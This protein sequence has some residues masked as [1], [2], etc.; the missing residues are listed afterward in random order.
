MIEIIPAVMPTSTTDLQ[1]KLAQVAGHMSVVQIDVMDGKFVKNVSWPYTEDEE[2]FQGILNE[3]E[4]LP[5]WDQFDFEV[6]LMIVRPEE[7]INDWI[8]A[9]VRRIVVHQESTDN[10]E[11]IITDFRERFP[12]SERPDVFD[13]EIGVAQNIETSVESIFPFLDRIDFVQFMGIDVIGEQG[14]SFDERVLDKIR[15]LREHSPEIII[16]V[17]GGVSLDTAPELI[18]AGVNRL[19]VGSAIFKSEDI[20]ATIKEFKHLGN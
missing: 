7:V 19:V 4:G 14:N 10:L 11:K 5:Y 9:G 2:Y 20:G 1:S 17:D 16:S 15:A 18:A 3:D 13:C 12:K 6:D 8:T